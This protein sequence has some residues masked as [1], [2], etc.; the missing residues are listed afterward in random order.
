MS[1]RKAV[2]LLLLALGGCSGDANVFAPSV[3][4]EITR[5]GC[6]VNHGSLVAN[7]TSEKLPGERVR[8]VIEIVN[9]K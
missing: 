8:C 7:V 4:V 3:Q 9:P 6:F 1:V 5:Q 2:A